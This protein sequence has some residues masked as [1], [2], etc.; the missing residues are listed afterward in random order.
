MLL[1]L[2]KKLSEMMAYCAKYL[3]SA[4]ETVACVNLGCCHCRFSVFVNV[5]VFHVKK[6]LYL[7]EI[8]DKAK[9][10]SEPSNY[11]IIMFFFLGVLISPNKPEIVIIRD[12]KF[13]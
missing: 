11:C 12:Y 13:T 7:A 9:S 5:K 4:K 10:K 8:H 6:I 2:T 1:C 3:K